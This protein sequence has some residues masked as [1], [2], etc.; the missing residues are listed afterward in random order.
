MIMKEIFM[1]KKISLTLTSLCLAAGM[2]FSAQAAPLNSPWA[3]SFVAEAEQIGILPDFMFNDDLTENITREEFCELAY[4]TIEQAADLNSVVIT[5]LAR[6]TNFTDTDN[7]AVTALKRMGVITG[8]TSTKF[9]PESLL[10]REEAAV[11]LNNMA[12]YFELTKF[13]NNNGFKDRNSIS[14]WAKESVDNVCGMNIMSGIGDGV[15]DPG[16]NYTKEQA[17]STMV[18]F[19]NS[20]PDE[21]SKEKIDN[22]KYYMSNAYFRGVEDDKGRVIFKLPAS[23]YTDVNFY[24]NGEKVLA[25]AAADG[26]T[27]I[28]DIENGR[29]LFTIPG[30]VTG[31]TSDKYI[32]AEAGDVYGVYDFNGREILPIQHDWDYLYNEKYVTSGEKA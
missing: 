16:G 2:C 5:Y 24:S 15:F 8:R 17:V 12:D 22:T 7:K 30:L 13:V 23:Q 4:L 32:I 27:D 26:Y 19:F 10:T 1:K 14:S 21:A 6:E 3:D 29:K 20:F 31:T 18:R 28:Y 25:F 11:I 9:E